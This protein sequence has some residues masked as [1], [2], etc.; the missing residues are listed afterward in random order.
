[1]KDIRRIV[2]G[3]NAEGRSIVVSDGIPPNVVKLGEGKTAGWE[4]W[5]TNSIPADN[6]GND[7]PTAGR[8]MG[9]HP[10]ANGSAFRMVAFAPDSV[11]YA[12]DE[13]ESPEVAAVMDTVRDHSREARHPNFHRTDT[14]DYAVIISGEI[15]ALLDED[16]LLM[17]PGDTLIQR[18]THH[19]WANRSDDYCYVAFV[20]IDAQPAV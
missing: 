3:H 11:M 6:S 7:D 19:A 1:M 15:W 16:E 5:E 18:G 8:P 13:Q 9:I 2:T 10:P 12:D 20:L 17:K 14:I 4:L